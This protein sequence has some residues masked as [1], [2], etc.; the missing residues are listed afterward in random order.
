MFC[1]HYWPKHEWSIWAHPLK[2]SFYTAL[3]ILSVICA[4][5]VSSWKLDLPATRHN[6]INRERTTTTPAK[7]R[8]THIKWLEMRLAVISPLTADNKQMPLDRVSNMYVS[9]S[10]YCVLDNKEQ[11]TRTSC[12]CPGQPTQTLICIITCLG[13]TCG[14]ILLSPSKHACAVRIQLI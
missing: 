4:S 13:I 9:L 5:L 7:K 10:L 2:Y 1:E 12:C 8:N 14:I 3:N 6:I 11:N